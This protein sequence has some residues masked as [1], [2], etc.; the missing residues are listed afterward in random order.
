MR[1]SRSV[2]CNSV[3]LGEKVAYLVV[4]LTP[5]TDSFY[6]ICLFGESP[7][8]SLDE[9]FL[10]FSEWKLEGEGPE[11]TGEE[12]EPDLG[13]EVGRQLPH[14]EVD[15]VGLEE[16]EVPVEGHVEEVGHEGDLGDGLPEAPGEEVIDDTPVP[17]AAGEGH[18]HEAETPPSLAEGVERP[19]LDEVNVLA[20]VPAEVSVGPEDQE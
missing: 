3:L 1:M 10:N 16:E 19:P 18:P 7:Q 12:T 5:T 20:R 2:C 6:S 8:Q 13:H 14:G 17:S 4:F 9:N 11:E 15:R